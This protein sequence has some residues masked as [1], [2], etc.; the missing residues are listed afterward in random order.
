MSWEVIRLGAEP[1]IIALS[2][3]HV[4]KIPPNPL[5]LNAGGERGREE[6]MKPRKYGKV[7]ER[8]CTT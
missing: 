5:S 7:C 8:G 6:A 3:G 2:I 1:T 4:V